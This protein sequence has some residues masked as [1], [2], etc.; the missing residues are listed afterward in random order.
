MVSFVWFILSLF[1]VC[2][3][4][5]WPVLI[6]F[7]VYALC[8]CISM[9]FTDDPGENAMAVVECMGSVIFAFA[10]LF[11]G[12]SISNWWYLPSGLWF[13]LALIVPGGF[14]I[15]NLVFS[16]YGWMELPTWVFVVG[17]VVDALEVIMVI[18]AIVVNRITDR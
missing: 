6:E 16:H 9:C 4:S 17:I 11:L 14:T 1:D 10:K 12:L 2:T 7:S 15:T 3:F 13:I 8:G 5:W 18:A